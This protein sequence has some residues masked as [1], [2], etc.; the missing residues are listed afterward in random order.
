MEIDSHYNYNNEQVVDVYKNFLFIWMK[1]CRWT[2]DLQILGGG[3]YA[4]LLESATDLY[5]TI[6]TT[7][8]IY[9]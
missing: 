6:I 2:Y 1:N 8:N 3:G 7:N 4:P 9:K 5:N